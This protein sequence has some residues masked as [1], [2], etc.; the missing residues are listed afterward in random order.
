MK[1]PV[2]GIRTS[3]IALLPASPPT[4]AAKAA[5][6]QAAAQV[7]DARQT[8]QPLSAAPCTAGAAVDVCAAGRCIGALGCCCASYGTACTAEFVTRAAGCCRCHCGAVH[9]QS[10]STETA[11]RGCVTLAAAQCARPCE[12]RAREAASGPTA[13]APLAA[14]SRLHARFSPR[15]WPRH[16][17]CCR[18]NTTVATVHAPLISA[19]AWSQC[20]RLRSRRWQLGLDHEPSGRYRSSPSPRPC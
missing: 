19:P 20:A 11:A 7:A 13:V 6:L 9:P 4:A 14:R 15:R 8:H 3:P 10:Q 16:H 18:T 2:A 12:R 5:G 1:H 17:H